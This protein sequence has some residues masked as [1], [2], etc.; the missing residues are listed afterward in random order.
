MTATPLLQ[1]VVLAFGLCSAAH[2]SMVGGWW[3]GSWKCNIDGRPARMNWAAVDDSESS[4]DGDT[5]TSTSGAKWSGKFSDNGSRWVPL[6]DAREGS[7]GGVFFRH[8]DGNQWYL[9]KPVG[10]K[11]QGYTTW[12]GKRYPLACTR[13]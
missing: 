12:Q 9:A 7:K 13:T 1:S 8:A 4:C 10:G 5:C 6:R 2:A 3:G 11:A